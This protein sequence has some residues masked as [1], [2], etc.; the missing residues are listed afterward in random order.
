MRLSKRWKIVLGVVGGA[1]L[2]FCLVFAVGLV[3]A[4]RHVQQI[5]MNS[6]QD[7]FNGQVTLDS[8]EIK[9]FPFVQ[10]SGTGVVLR[11]E[12]REDLPP[13][14]AVKSFSARASWVGLMRLPRHISHVTLEG[15]QIT[16]P[17]AQQAGADERAK[18]KKSLGRFHAVVMDDVHSENATLTI[19]PKQ[20]GKQPQVFEI[21]RLE[22]HPASQQGAMTFQT[23]LRNPAPPGDIHSSGTFG[24]WNP[25][26]PGLTPVS[27]TY[28]YKNADLG[29][30]KGIAGILSSEG[31]YGGVI[32][33]ITV[34][35][36]TDTPDFSVNSG[37]HPVDLSTTFHA[38]VDGANG[39]TLLQPVDSHFGKTTVHTTGSIAGT[40]G[41]K[42]KTISLDVNATQARIEDLLLLVLKD[43]PAMTGDIQ[44]T[45]RMILSPGGPKEEMPDR[46]FLDGS[47]RIDRM[48][49]T[50]AGINTKVDTLSMRSRGDTGAADADDRV[51]SEIKGK[52]RLQNG[53]ITF[54][55][56]GFRVPG[57]SVQMTGTFGLE[58]QALDLHGALKMQASLSQATTGA[59]SFFL[60]AVDPLFAQAGGGGTL[61]HFK[62][63]GTAKH[64]VYGLDL[65]RKP[66][67]ARPKKEL[68][69]GAPH[70]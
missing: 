30:F 29:H 61:L 17:T 2:A 50:N 63:T 28:T 44:L 43:Q 38:I 32:Q 24:P 69:A 22:M 65:H 1:V 56:L 13:L 11:F 14:I 40:P 9:T 54:S 45:A 66:Q 52:F 55:E 49:F 51:A 5:V 3:W 37:R 31:S 6:L 62:I 23:T 47:F 35:G 4:S 68:S 27:G 42:G 20:A 36:A 34:D 58:D 48:Y 64:P 15:L 21:A 7:Q 33:E 53:V 41:K 26:A 57:A 16:I 8:I 59:K 39:D 67:D 46:L 25:D 12:G 60:K 70:R 19:L 18:I 10:V